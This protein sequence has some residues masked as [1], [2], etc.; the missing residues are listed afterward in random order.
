VT[1]DENDHFVGSISPAALTRDD[2]TYPKLGATLT[3]LT[4][5]RN[6]ITVRSP[7]AELLG[8]S[9]IRPRMN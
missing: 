5:A 3:E 4:N 6:E 2:A 9:D 7:I 8:T 1:A